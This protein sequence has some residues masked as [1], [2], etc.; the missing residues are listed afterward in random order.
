MTDA[1]KCNRCG[2][3]SE[4]KPECLFK[5][6]NPFQQGLTDSDT[7]TVHLCGECQESLTEFMDGIGIDR[8]VDCRTER[9]DY[10]YD[11]SGSSIPDSESWSSA[12]GIKD[13]DIRI[14]KPL[15]MRRTVL[16]E[17]V[18]MGATNY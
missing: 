11:T 13:F 7:R 16:K 15:H 14:K 1:Y 8:T 10:L 2:K 6:P 18:D 3:Y 9:L 17:Q 12:F 5:F 4:G